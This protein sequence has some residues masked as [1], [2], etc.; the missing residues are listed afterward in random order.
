MLEIQ[1]I[2]VEIYLPYLEDLYQSPGSFGVII[3][4]VIVAKKGKD[5]CI[6]YGYDK[7]W[8]SEKNS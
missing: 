1:N 4:D 6:N 3:G 2:L 8:D 7:H 5:T